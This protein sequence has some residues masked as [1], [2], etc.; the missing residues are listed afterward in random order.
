MR[1]SQKRY[2]RPYRKIPFRPPHANSVVFDQRKSRE[3]SPFDLK[4]LG[5]ARPQIRY[6]LTLIIATPALL[7]EWSYK[8]Y[9]FIKP[10]GIKLV[11]AY[12]TK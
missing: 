11:I 8:R 7:I 3:E 12:S 5:V 2:R 4:V 6:G 9:K 1:L 10:H